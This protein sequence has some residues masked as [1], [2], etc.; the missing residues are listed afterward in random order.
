SRPAPA[1]AGATTAGACAAS[2]PNWWRPDAPPPVAR[3]RAAATDVMALPRPRSG[4]AA[5]LGGGRGL[6]LSEQ[7]ALAHRAAQLAQDR[8]LRFGLHAFADAADAQRA[9][10]RQDRA[11]Q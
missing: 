4:R 1:P 6:R 5:A 2:S 3:P 9:G 11:H 8:G 10:Q 7:E